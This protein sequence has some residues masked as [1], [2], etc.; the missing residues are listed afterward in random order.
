MSSTT[1]KRQKEIA[2]KIEAVFERLHGSA[3]SKGHFYENDFFIR[4][5]FA[6][7]VLNRD[8]EILMSFA[9]HTRP[10]YAA[11]YALLLAEIEGTDL[12]ICQDYKTD[13]D[14][15]MIIDEVA[16]KSTGSII[17]DQKKKYYE[18]LKE[19]LSKVVIRKIKKD[20]RENE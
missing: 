7:V 12:I 5:D 15:S 16:G 10:S 18:M 4:S 3:Y 11:L 2:T 13:K 8:D 19:R 17:W 14:G 20:G 6:L 1:E 9:D